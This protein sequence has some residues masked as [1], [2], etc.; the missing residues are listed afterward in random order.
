VK[1]IEAGQVEQ[2]LN[3]PALVA[4][5]EVG[6]GSDFGMPPRQVFQLSGAGSSSHDG[7]RCCRHG[8]IL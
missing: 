1:I 2:A 5:L 6:F 7:L 4:A 8:M 3:F